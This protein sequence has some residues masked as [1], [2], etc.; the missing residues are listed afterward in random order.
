M[1]LRLSTSCTVLAAIALL[2]ACQQTTTTPTQALSLTSSASSIRA[3]QSRNIEASDEA[4][5]LGAVVS[6]LQDF[7]FKIEETQLGAG[8]VSG[9]KQQ[10]SGVFGNL[11][12]DIRVSV[13]SKMVD[14][15]LAIVRANFQK[16]RRSQQVQ[17][18][19]AEP[20]DDPLIFTKFFDALQQALF[21]V[22][23]EV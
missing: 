4:T 8:I 11:P 5:L 2:S 16:I 1:R 3:Q 23:N 7:G 17:L 6:T 21:L 15:G 22:R 9:S 12:Y 20:I 13:S 14:K 19:R 18:T 10:G